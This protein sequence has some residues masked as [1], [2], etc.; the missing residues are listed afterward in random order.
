MGFSPSTVLVQFASGFQVVNNPEQSLSFCVL[1]FWL[2]WT[3]LHGNFL[4]IVPFLSFLLLPQPAPGLEGS[5]QLCKCPTAESNLIVNILTC[6]CELK[7][8]FV[9]FF[10]SLSHSEP[11]KM[12]VCES[13]IFARSTCDMSAD[14]HS[15][16]RLWCIYL[17]LSHSSICAH[18]GTHTQHEGT[19]EACF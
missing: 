15:P 9:F 18:T 10:L 4:F 2:C 11:V 17:F 6:P 1:C 13:Q 8:A 19:G 5:Q 12:Y 3:D 7:Q 16:P 14:M